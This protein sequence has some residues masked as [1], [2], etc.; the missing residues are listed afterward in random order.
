MEGNKFHDFLLRICPVNIDMHWIDFT[1]QDAAVIGW[2]NVMALHETSVMPTQEWRQTI[3]QNKEHGNSIS[4]DIPL[5]S[6]ALVHTSDSSINLEKLFATCNLFIT[7]LTRELTD[8]KHKA[9]STIVEETCWKS[10]WH[11]QICCFH[12]QKCLVWQYEQKVYIK[13]I[14]NVSC[15]RELFNQFTRWTRHF[16]ASHVPTEIISYWSTDQSFYFA[17]HIN[18]RFNPGGT[19]V[20]PIADILHWPC[21]SFQ[22][23]V[24]YSLRHMNT[25]TA[26][27]VL[28]AFWNQALSKLWHISDLH[29]KL[30]H[31]LLH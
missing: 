30:T 23:R 2:Q 7:K 25:R 12:N 1:S 19:G 18:K 14:K 24:F 31:M 6:G 13:T 5:P 21:Y 16:V 29:M 15:W 4:Y 10:C 8:S 22:F 26:G 27:Y 9:Y 3:K 20:L 17:C 28:N 11:F